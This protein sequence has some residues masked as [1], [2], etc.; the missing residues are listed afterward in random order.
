MGKRRSIRSLRTRPSWRGEGLTAAEYAGR[1][2]LA[3]PRP[4]ALDPDRLARHI[5]Q[6]A[7][8]IG[9]SGSLIRIAFA[10]NSCYRVRN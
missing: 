4:T 5:V 7:R 3:E 6:A 8:A 1:R 9:R 10:L 2:R